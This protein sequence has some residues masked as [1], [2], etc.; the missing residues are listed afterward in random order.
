MCTSCGIQGDALCPFCLTDEIINHC[1]LNNTIREFKCKLCI[2]NSVN[3]SV[4]INGN[5]SNTTST[6]SPRNNGLARARPHTTTTAGASSV[7]DAAV[8]TQRNFQLNANISDNN[9]YVR[10]DNANAIRDENNVSNINVNNIQDENI[11]NANNICNYCKCKFKTGNP[12]ICLNCQRSFH[13]KCYK[14]VKLS[15]DFCNICISEQLPFHTNDTDNEPNITDIIIPSLA[16]ENIFECLEGKGLQFIHLNARSMFHKL[17]EIDYIA[18][19]VNPAIISISETWFD[20]SFTDTSVDIEGYKIKRR[21]RDTRSGGVCVYIRDNLDFHLREDLQN[22][23]LEDLWIELLFPKT[24]P[25]IVGTCYR[26][27]DNSA[28]KDCIEAT[29]TKLSPGCDA[30]LLG[31]FNYCLLNNKKTNKFSQT[32]KTHGFTQIIK[33]PTRVTNNSTSLID[34]IYT[35]NTNKINKAGV[36]ETGISDHFITYCIRKALKKQWGQIKVLKLGQ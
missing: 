30:I 10:T 7:P 32:L 11:N 16:P 3:N 34:H 36:I 26:A 6:N 35:N 4:N 33:T 13:Y 5:N 28:A 17:P 20:E 8:P 12:K 1:N 2:A 24:K 14:Q 21:D 25:L 29:L 23:A 22:D 15:K 18:K 31:D 19:K 9:T 27:P